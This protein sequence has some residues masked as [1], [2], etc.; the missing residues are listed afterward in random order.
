MDFVDYYF[1]FIFIVIIVVIVALVAYFMKSNKIL[2]KGIKDG[3]YMLKNNTIYFTVSNNKIKHMNTDNSKD[4]VKTQFKVV[5]D[6]TER[7]VYGTQ[8][9][10]GNTLYIAQS[11]YSDTIYS[12]VLEDDDLKNIE[13]GTYTKVE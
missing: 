8:G 9:T 12:Y 1:Y 5:I 7:V 4:I 10:T 2:D 11:P 3:K 6:G 13:A